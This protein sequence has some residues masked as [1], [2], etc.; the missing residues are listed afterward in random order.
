MLPGRIGKPAAA[1]VP[2]LLRLRSGSDRYWA[3]KS[4]GLFGEVAA[5]AVDQLAPELHDPSR[6]Y[7]DRILVA[8]VLGQIGTG[9]AIEALGRELVQSGRSQ[10][11]DSRS[12]D[13]ASQLLIKTMLD[14]IALAG[15][16]AVGAL[17][18]IVRS[19]E[20]P[21]CEIRRKACQA[22]GQLGPRAESSITNR[23][24]G[25]RGQIRVTSSDRNRRQ[26]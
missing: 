3:L 22:I 20:N 15:P 17:P 9:P 12:G 5:S 8:D 14:A 19:L 1:A 21:D 4:L 26:S 25:G 6:G 2:V 16:R 23:A 13:A 18:A 10:P 11:G 7:S 24:S